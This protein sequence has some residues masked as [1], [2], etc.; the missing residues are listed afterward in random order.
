MSTVKKLGKRPV[1]ACTECVRL[2][3]KCDRTYPCSSCIKRGKSALCAPAEESSLPAR[4]TSSPLVDESGSVVGTSSE[5]RAGARSELALFRKTFESLQSRLSY[6]E[7][8]VGAAAHASDDAEPSSNLGRRQRTADEVDA[9]GR[10]SKRAAVQSPDEFTIEQ[11]VLDSQRETPEFVGPRGLPFFDPQKQDSAMLLPSA[12]NI[13]RLFPSRSS[14]AAVGPTK[15]VSDTLIH[16]CMVT[17]GALHPVASVPARTRHLEL[18]W[19]VDGP[20]QYER[21]FAAWLASFFAQ[22]AV[23]AR[24]ATS[25][26][27]RTLGMDASMLEE[28]AGH[29]TDAS[30]ASLYYSN[31]LENR[32]MLA[33]QAVGYLALSGRTAGNFRSIN[34]LVDHSMIALRQLRLHLDIDAVPAPTVA[35]ATEW[36]TKASR[37]IRKRVCWAL[38]ISHWLYSE[39]PFISPDEVKGAPPSVMDVGSTQRYG[40]LADFTSVAYLNFLFDVARVVYETRFATELSPPRVSTQRAALDRLQQQAEQDFADSP[41]LRS[42][43][44]VTTSYWILRLLRQPSDPRSPETLE[45]ARIML[46]EVPT[47]QEHEGHH[48]MILHQICAAALVICGI[49]SDNATDDASGTPAADAR[50]LDAAEGYFVAASHNSIAQKSLALIQQMRQ[51]LVRPPE[52]SS[53]PFVDPTAAFPSASGAAFDPTLDDLLADTAILEY[54]LPE[55]GELRNGMSD[56]DFAWWS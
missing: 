38:C 23:G 52:P 48:W 30:I 32:S 46:R 19:S 20:A 56:L 55:Y 47:L 22:L 26:V 27:C 2:K 8:L 33:L 9:D 36:E 12:R 3:S 14:L 31:F 43:S 53:I 49:A 40:D 4:S 18:F 17:T 6:L 13:F 10:A 21:C 5:V 25:D 41:F 34:S 45:T 7:T 54:S 11:N 35:P 16:H 44:R 39:H 50:L 1:R 42:F 37:E 29:W 28:L 24:L 51:P 15:T